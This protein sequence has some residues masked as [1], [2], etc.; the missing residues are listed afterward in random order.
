LFPITIQNFHLHVHCNDS[1]TAAKILSEVKHHTK[2]LNKLNM[3]QEELVASLETA[4]AKADK[5]ITEVQALKDLVSTTPDVPQ[6]V[7][8]A[9][10]NLNAKLD[11]L[12]AI[13]EDAP[14]EEPTDP[15]A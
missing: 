12:D 5:V 3:T 15:E 9:V 6:V 8:D 7:V 10:N 14:V 2:I 1:D 13:N 11:Q 4:N